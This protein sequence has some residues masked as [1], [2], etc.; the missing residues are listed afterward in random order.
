MEAVSQANEISFFQSL[1]NMELFK[2]ISKRQLEVRQYRNANSYQHDTSIKPL[3][4]NAPF[5]YPM[6]SS[7]G[8]KWEQIG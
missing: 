7:L 6:K 3:I 5:L 8:T 2:L 4:P 1:L